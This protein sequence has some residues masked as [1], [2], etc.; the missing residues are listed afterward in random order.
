MDWDLNDWN[1]K[2]EAD[3]QKVAQVIAEVAE[4]EHRASNPQSLYDGLEHVAHSLGC[5]PEYVA[6]AI[7]KYDESNHEHQDDGHSHHHHHPHGDEVVAH[8]A[9]NEDTRLQ[10]HPDLETSPLLLDHHDSDENRPIPPQLHL[11][12]HVYHPQPEFVAPDATGSGRDGDGDGRVG[13]G[14]N[15]PTSHRTNTSLE[16]DDES[17]RDTLM[18][19]APTRATFLNQPSIERRLRSDHS[20]DADVED[21]TSLPSLDSV[22]TSHASSSAGH[23]HHH[24]HDIE[25]EEKVDNNT[26]D[27]DEDCDAHDAEALTNAS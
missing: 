27:E 18:P 8:D 13:D 21:H 22:D 1:E 11:H 9:L 2:D 20:S 6:A 15:M 10:H 4:T 25:E 24:H 14:G 19:L 17:Y 3:L 16:Y 23:H 26:V 5:S 12:A 7:L